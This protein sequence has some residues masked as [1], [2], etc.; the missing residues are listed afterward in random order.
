MEGESVDGGQLDQAVHVA[1]HSGHGIGEDGIV[2]PDPSNRAAGSLANTFGLAT[3]RRHLAGLREETGGVESRVEA[4][5]QKIDRS[6]DQI[7][8]LLTQLVER[9]PGAC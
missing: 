8:G 7:I 2:V 9:R 1:Q 3:V 6:H 5:D 4:L